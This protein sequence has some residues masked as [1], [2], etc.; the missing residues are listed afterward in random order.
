MNAMFQRSEISIHRELKQGFDNW[1]K[2]LRSVPQRGEE[3]Q[4]GLESKEKNSRQSDL[5]VIEATFA[6]RQG[7]EDGRWQDDGGQ[8]DSVY[9]SSTSSHNEIDFAGQTPGDRL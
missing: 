3:S 5:H 1:V 4:P 8:C 2:G 9:K 6:G 7:D